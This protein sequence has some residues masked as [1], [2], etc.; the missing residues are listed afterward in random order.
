MQWLQTYLSF[1]VNRV[2]ESA[3][4]MPS[5]VDICKRKRNKGPYHGV[6]NR[7]EKLTTRPS[8]LTSLESNADTLNRTPGKRVHMHNNSNK[9]DADLEQH[10]LHRDRVLPY[11]ATIQVNTSPCVVAVNKH[12]LYVC[13]LPTR[14]EKQETSSFSVS[15]RVYEA[16]TG[17][18][19]T[20]SLFRCCRHGHRLSLFPRA[21]QYG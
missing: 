12:V 8:P 21:A 7:Q 10:L 9:H 19:W 11:C 20:L 4:V 5:Q 13:K 17:A 2:L 3:F 15:S 16:S 6:I 18:A 1:K 14:N